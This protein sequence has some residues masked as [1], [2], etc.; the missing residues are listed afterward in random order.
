MA[1]I[2]SGAQRAGRLRGLHRHRLG[3]GFRVEHR[4]KGNPLCHRNHKT[5]TAGAGIEVT[6][7]DAATGAPLAGAEFTLYDQYGAAVRTAVTGSD[8]RATF[9]NVAPGLYTIQETRAPSGY[10]PS[11]SAISVT[12]AAGQTYTYLVEN[13]A[14]TGGGGNGG[15]STGGS[16]EDSDNI[17]DDGTPAGGGEAEDT[18]DIGDDGLPKTGGLFDTVTL[19]VLG[20]G[21]AA[22]GVI[23]LIVTRKKRENRA[24]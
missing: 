3:D 23:V 18:D 11:G 7:I 1:A 16:G 4:R 22:I 20:A 12:A 15:G 24:E 10:T 21:L 19:S 14:Q 13:T 8:G 17:G 6:K 9:A 5:G 2:P